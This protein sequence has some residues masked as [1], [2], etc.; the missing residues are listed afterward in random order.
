VLGV[1][2]FLKGF[3]AIGVTV[4]LCA[5]L[6]G[7]ERAG[8][9]RG[10]IGAVSGPPTTPPVVERL[11]ESLYRIGAIRIDRAERT[12]SVSGFVNPGL[13]GLEFVANSR[14]GPKAYESVLTLDTDAVAFNTALLLIGLDRARTKNAPQR[15]FDPAVPEGDEVEIT[16]ECAVECGGRMPAERLLYDRVAQA[17]LRGGTW[18][19]TGSQFMP[20]GRYL[21]QLDGVL[22]SFV[23]TPAAII[24]YARGAGLG[25]Y[26]SIVL[27]PALKLAPDTPVTLTVKA[28]TAAN[29]Q[30]GSA[31]R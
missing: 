26:G 27:N 2:F 8:R 1:R 13:T 16:V 11:G 21:A 20:D 4:V 22:V 18:V 19:Y 17:P 3:L 6:T 14:G 25:R 10:P 29:P 7:Q 28:L 23:H 24:E 30:P 9:G 15:H 5:S 12:V 31:G